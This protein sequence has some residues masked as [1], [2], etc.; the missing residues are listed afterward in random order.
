MVPKAVVLSSILV[1]SFLVT[2]TTVLA[3]SDQRDRQSGVCPSMC[4][5]DMIDKLKRADCR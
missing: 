1:L 2:T 5:C 3:E 4:T